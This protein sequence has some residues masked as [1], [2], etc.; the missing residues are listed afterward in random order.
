MNRYVLLHRRPNTDTT[1]VGVFPERTEPIALA[2]SRAGGLCRMG[3]FFEELD[4]PGEV[5]RIA[6]GPAGECFSVVQEPPKPFE[7]PANPVRL[8]RSP[9]DRMRW[10]FGQLRDQLDGEWDLVDALVERDSFTR[11]VPGSPFLGKFPG[12][13]LFYSLH[14]RLNESARA[15]LNVSDDDRARVLA[16]LEDDVE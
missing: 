7:S 3:Q 16:A 9:E 15:L 11:E 4:V 1:V 10:L 14:L 13:N 2:R 8:H 5:L 12:P 6:Y